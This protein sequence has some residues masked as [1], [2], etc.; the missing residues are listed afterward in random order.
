MLPILI[1]LIPVFV[2]LIFLILLDNYKLLK[3]AA[4]YKAIGFGILSAVVCFMINAGSR[5]LIGERALTLYSAP[6][7]EEFFKA[8][9]PLYLIKKR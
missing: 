6:V 4:I 5:P 2:F 8:L 1:S 9:L 7:V 3:P